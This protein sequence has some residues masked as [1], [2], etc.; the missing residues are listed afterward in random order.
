LH[1]L[2]RKLGQLDSLLAGNL[3]QYR[4]SRMSA[5]ERAFSAML[6]RLRGL[7]SEQRRVAKRTKR[8]IRRYQRRATQMMKHRIAP[9]V[10][11]ELGKL[12]RLRKRVGEIDPAAL[13]A[14]D[15]EQLERIRQ[16]VRDLKGM[17]DQGDIDEALRMAMRTRNG[18]Q[19]LQ[20]DLAEEIEGQHPRRRGQ[21]RRAQHKTR[22]AAKL[23][24][25]LAADLRAIFPSP[26]T[27]LDGDDRRELRRLQADQRGLRR[28]LQQLEAQ[29]DKESRHAALFGGEVPQAVKE[30]AGLMGKASNKLA[31][32]QPQEAHGSQ[33]A[34]ADRLARL[35]QQME[36]AR[37]PRQW[38]QAGPSVLRERIHIPGADAFRPPKEFRKDI[39]D[40]MKEK[41]PRA[42]RGQVKRYYEELVR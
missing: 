10:R 42:F 7:E 21:I 17:L 26:R 4:N 9:F 37:Q 25:E 2:D 15:Q 31:S 30:S 6:D 35:R 12:Q 24:G 3:D 32:L 23:A 19:V 20:D 16:R 18:L 13:P 36:E 34:A 11:R 14:Y 40:A 27:L 38:S 33:E 29:L 22:L 41:A 8:V 28:K 39:L 5:R 1:A